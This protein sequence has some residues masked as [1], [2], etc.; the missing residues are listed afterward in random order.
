LKFPLE[1]TIRNVHESQVGLKLNGTDQPLVH[2]GDVSLLGDNII[3][4]KKNTDILIDASKEVV[5]EVNA[6]KT[7]PKCRAK[8]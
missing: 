7:L 1:Y 5:L 3:I 8:S 2:A 4:I 6:G